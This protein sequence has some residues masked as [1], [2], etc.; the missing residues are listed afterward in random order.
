M[1][2]E[3]LTGPQQRQEF[4]NMGREFAFEG[5]EKELFKAESS[6]ELE[7]FSKGYEAALAY[8]EEQQIPEET[9]IIEGPK[10][11]R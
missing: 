7:A 11:G 9:E 5:L 6:E 1:G 4:Y 8:I 2:L 10:M 3:R